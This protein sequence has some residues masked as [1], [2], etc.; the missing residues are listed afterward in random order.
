[1]KKEEIISKIKT[2]ID[3]YG[4][5]KI[6]EVDGEAPIVLNTFGNDANEVIE[7]IHLNGVDVVSYVN[8]TELMTITLTIMI[9]LKI[10]F[11]IY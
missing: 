11:W 5:F 10:F 2:I 9:Y 4:S 8:E 7:Y 6:N 3:N 1:M